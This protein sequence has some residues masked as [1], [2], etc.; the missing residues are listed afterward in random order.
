MIHEDKN[1]SIDID[2][3]MVQMKELLNKDSKTT[4][5]G[6]PWWCSG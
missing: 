3:E 6:L 1:Q 4:I 2:P 5:T